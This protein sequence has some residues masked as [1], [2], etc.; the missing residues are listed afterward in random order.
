MRAYFIGVLYQCVV[1]YENKEEYVPLDAPVMPNW[2]WALCRYGMLQPTE[3]QDRFPQGV[4][5]VLNPLLR[6]DITLLGDGVH[7]WREFDDING[8][9]YRGVRNDRV[10]VTLAEFSLY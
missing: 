1:R 9:L 4:A 3:R 5:D 7:E 10:S 8:S 2:L 6:D